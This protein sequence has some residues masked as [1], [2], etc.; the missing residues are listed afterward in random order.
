M[1]FG[2]G[3]LHIRDDEWE[4]PVGSRPGAAVEG[5]DAGGPK[6]TDRKTELDAGDSRCLAKHVTADGAP[7]PVDVHLQEALGVVC[8]PDETDGVGGDRAGGGGPRGG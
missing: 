6:H 2:P 4:G 5:S 1:G 7:L 8:P 3:T